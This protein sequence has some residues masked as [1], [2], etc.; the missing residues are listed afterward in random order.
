[1]RH[2]TQFSVRQFHWLLK[3]FC[4]DS[5]SRIATLSALFLLAC[6]SALAQGRQISGTVSDDSGAPLPNVSVRIKGT[7]TGAFTDGQGKF[8][9]NVPNDTAVLVFSTIGYETQEMTVGSNTSLKVALKTSVSQLSDVVVVGYGSVQKRN[10][11]SAVTTV[12]AKDFLQGGY[13]SPLQMIDGKVAG[14]T[15]SN[16]AAADPNR[17]TDIQIR[18][19]ASLE[20]GNGPLVV[21]DGMPGGDLRNIAQQDIESITVLKDASA[22]AIY[23]SRG[24]NGVVLVQTKRGKSGDVTVTYDSYVEHDVVAAKPELLSPEEFLEKQR[25]QD[26]GARTNWYDELIRT[27]N[28][29]TNQFLTVSG[30]T[31]NSIFRL[32]GNYRS[33]TGI[34]I[35][36]ERKEYGYRANFQQKALNGLLEFSG[37]LSQRI[38]KEEYTNYNAFQQAVKLNPTLSVMDP[39]NPL[40]FNTLQGYDTYNPVQDLLA[41]E[42]GADQNYSIVDMNV[43]LNILKNLSTEIK[44]ARQGHEMLRREYYT[45]K[46]AES[47]NN[48]RL[49]RARLQ[50]EKWTDYTLEWLGNYNTTIDKHDFSLMGGYSYQE[51]NNQAF[52][53]E[54]MNFISDGFGYNNLDDGSWNLEEG[55]LGMDSYK[56]KEKLIAFLGRLNYNFDNTYFLTASFR[57]EGNSKFGANNKWGMFPAVSAAWRI[58][59]LDVFRGSRVI[60]DLKLRASYG[61][62]GRSGFARYT[63]LARYAPYGRYLNDAGEWVRVYGPGNN[64][65]PNLQW[66]RA[67]AYNI[68][69]DFVLLDNRITGSL[70]VF[71]RRSRDILG[72]YDVPVGAYLHEQMFVNVGTTSSK[73]IE[74]TANWK[75]AATEDFSYNTNVTASYIRTKLVS[76]SNNQFQGNFRYLQNL[77]SPGNPGPAYRL[78]PGT[79]LGSFYGYKYAGVDEDGRILIWKDG[80]EGKEKIVASSEGNADRDRTYIGHGAPRYELA[81]GNNF[82]YKGF[83]LSLFF[84]GRFDY[85]ILN[86]YQMYYGLQAEPGI[87]LLKDAYTRNGHIKSGKVITDYFL[88]KGDYFKL[89]NLTL[90]WS[91]K[92]HVKEIKNLRLYGSVRNVFT[93]T[94][95]SGLD[96]TVVGVTGLTPGYGDL[97]VYPITRT[98]TFGAQVTF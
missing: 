95:Y 90:G 11:T 3:R 66:E 88:E 72:N 94:G 17:G 78:D 44:L 8:S 1:M 19:A 20:A 22:A 82:T 5:G 81:W 25:D 69:L 89:D 48:N 63:S 16:P 98:F 97:G 83:D 6:M 2:S 40:N 18:G 10:L 84:R 87:N 96:P 33:K 79:E 37:N 41:R 52:W 7:T 92:L 80:I 30:G 47:V 39:D 71:D 85:D 42:N 21:I 53:A 46:S 86:L 73:G 9:F 65:N 15:V 61:V 23:G 35:A 26:R 68:G 32:S 38:A 50:S 24:A 93:F 67:V 76:W 58:S 31:A 75:V 62:T 14:V 28:F 57:Y 29:G 55:R 70:D 51:F 59:N 36:T 56:S 49:G 34:D 64:Y 45:S 77:P 74:L 13:N 60:N 27:N 91:P 12:N 54:N 43:K 4:K